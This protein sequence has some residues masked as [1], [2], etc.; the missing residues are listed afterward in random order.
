M[1][2]GFIDDEQ[3]GFRGKRGHVDQILALKQI[4]L[5]KRSF[6]DLEKGYDR[7]NREAIWQ[8]LRMH[9]VEWN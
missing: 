2:E 3:G 7:V 6:I 1:T 9:E 5:K 4:G 8:V